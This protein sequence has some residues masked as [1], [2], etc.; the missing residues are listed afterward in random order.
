MLKQF[1]N[2]YSGYVDKIFLEIL[3]ECNPELFTTYQKIQTLVPQSL[4]GA[5]EFK[6]LIKKK[7][8]PK[9]YRGALQIYCHFKASRGP[10]SEI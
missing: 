7:N 5:K 6:E 2:D 10:N 8:I 1:H 9:K 3:E 4:K